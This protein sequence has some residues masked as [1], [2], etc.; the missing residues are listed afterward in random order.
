[1]L[2][3]L[4]LGCLGREG[5]GPVFLLQCPLGL[6]GLGLVP[7]LPSLLGLVGLELVRG[8]GLVPSLSGRLVLGVLWLLPLP[9][10][11]LV[12]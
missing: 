7:L 12:G 5:L 10:G 3:L 2:G 8:P 4:V 1:M 6:A 11:L 9:R